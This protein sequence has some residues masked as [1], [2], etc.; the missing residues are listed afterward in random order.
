MNIH[1]PL[2]TITMVTNVQKAGRFYRREQ[3]V[4][5]LDH[6]IGRLYQPTKSADFARWTTDFCWPILLA[7][8]TGQLYRSS[9]IPLKVPEPTVA[10]TPMGERRLFTEPAHNSRS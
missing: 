3:N 7:D 8:K 4:F 10:T 5:Q 1:L 6:K 9:D 2:Q